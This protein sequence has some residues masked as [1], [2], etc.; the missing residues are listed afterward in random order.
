[1]LFGTL[2]IIGDSL[3]AGARAETS[4]HAGLGVPEHLARVLSVCTSEEWGVLNRAVSGQ[5]TRQIADRAPGAVRELL[6]YAGPRWVVFLAG[7]NDSKGPG[8]PIDEWEILYRQAAAWARRASLPLVLA[9]FPPVDPGA[10]PAFGRNANDW[11]AAASARVRSLALDWD[12]SPAPV[13]LVEL[14]DLPL[15]ALC[16]GVHFRPEAH[17]AVALRFADA[18]LRRPER[19]WSVLLDEARAVFARSD[20]T[21]VGP[22]PG[23]AEVCVADPPRAKR[24]KRT[25]AEA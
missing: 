14:S 8:V 19:P 22:G 25:E 5:T 21:R 11:L 2:A 15:D 16:D 9:T 18:M 10:M 1:M 20:A 13:V 23:G 6:A 12:G 3:L 7:T 17:L 24:R 4:G